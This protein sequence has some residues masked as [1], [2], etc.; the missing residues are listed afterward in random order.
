MTEVSKI[1]LVFSVSDEVTVLTCLLISLGKVV[2]CP[3]EVIETLRGFPRRSAAFDFDLLPAVRAGEL[4]I[5]GKLSGAG[6]ELLSALRALH[7]PS[8]SISKSGHV[9]SSVGSFEPSQRSGPPGVA[10]AASGELVSRQCEATVN[11]PSN[12]AC[13][14]TADRASAAS[15]HPI[16][17]TERSPAVVPGVD[18]P[19]VTPAA[20]GG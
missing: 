12:L 3:I 8:D 5:T 20:A 13:G 16:L 7:V 15:A 2:P 11:A 18:D 17:E 14:D 6:L 10:E 1:S 4:R 19:S 9:S